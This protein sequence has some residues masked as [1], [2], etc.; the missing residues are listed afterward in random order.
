MMRVTG[1][2]KPSLCS[3]SQVCRPS[4]ARKSSTWV[5]QQ[6]SCTVSV[7]ASDAGSINTSKLSSDL[8]AA[9]ASNSIPDVA[10]ASFPSSTIETVT[11]PPQSNLSV[12]GRIKRFFL[13]DSGFDKKKL[14]ELGLGAFAAYGVFSN[15][16]AGQY[17]QK[18]RG[19]SIEIDC[20]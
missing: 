7:G 10:I 6:R 3:R 1:N 19:I 16:N 15:M 12:L 4:A 13:G 20:A 14:A 5:V 2:L 8:S 9:S 17:S 18:I 11:P